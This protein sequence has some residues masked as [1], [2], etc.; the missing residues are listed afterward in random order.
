[1]NNFFVDLVVGLLH[2]SLDIWRPALVAGSD[3]FTNV[4]RY[5]LVANIWLVN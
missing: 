1:M 2:N 5:Y 3:P 4:W